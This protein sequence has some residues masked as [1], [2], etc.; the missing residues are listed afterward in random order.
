MR[1]PTLLAMWG[2]PLWKPEILASAE[3]GPKRLLKGDPMTDQQQP[4]YR[5]RVGERGWIVG[6]AEIFG[7][8]DTSDMYLVMLKSRAGRQFRAGRKALEMVGRKTAWADKH[9][10]R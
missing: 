10:L 4:A 9:S 5:H 3:T 8:T 2:R 1:T 7:V 6:K